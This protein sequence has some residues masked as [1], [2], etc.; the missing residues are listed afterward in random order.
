MEQH[1]SPSEPDFGRL[2]EA[3]AVN[4]DR[5]AFADL[6]EFFA[7]RLTA[8]FIRAGANAAHAEDLA[9]DVM[10][11]VW[12]KAALYDGTRA[13]SGWIFAIARNKRIDAFRKQIRTII[14]IDPVDDGDLQLE[15]EHLL[16]EQQSAARLHEALSGLSEDQLQLLQLSFFGEKAHA[17]IAHDL[18]MPLGTVKA[19]IRRAMLRLRQT[20]ADL[21]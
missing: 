9:Q 3:V 19:K 7:P 11:L 16:I 4:G 18:D 6:F 13:A 17:E 21:R 20:L 14:P 10:L 15:P 5:A 12:R 8:Y 2:I 1:S